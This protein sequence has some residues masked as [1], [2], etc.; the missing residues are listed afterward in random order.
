[1]LVILILSLS[2][3]LEGGIGT[4][5]FECGGL[6]SPFQAICKEGNIDFNK[7]FQTYYTTIPSLALSLT[8]LLI[9]IMRAYG[10]AWAW[11][12]VHGFLLTCSFHLS[13]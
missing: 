6:C 11:G 4:P 7:T 2:K 8:W 12:W 5:S 3:S 13:I 9:H 10:L 1:M